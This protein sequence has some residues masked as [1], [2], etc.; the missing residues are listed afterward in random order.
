MISIDPVVET[1]YRVDPRPAADG[2]VCG[3]RVIWVNAFL[4]QTQT[5]KCADHMPPPPPPPPLP[6]PPVAPPTQNQDRS[7][8]Q[9]DTDIAHLNKLSRRECWAE[10]DVMTGQM[11]Y[12]V[13]LCDEYLPDLTQFLAHLKQGG[14]IDDPGNIAVYYTGWKPPIAMKDITDWITAYMAKYIS[15]QEDPKPNGWYWYWSALDVPW[16]VNSLEL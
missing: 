1:I 9:T 3:E 7:T 14:L 10:E 13:E 16:Y 8:S 2:R 11:E 4:P 5:W 15:L 6:P 12:D